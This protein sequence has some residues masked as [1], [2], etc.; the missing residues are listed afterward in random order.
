M[1]NQ[2]GT[3]NITTN[4]RM[5][6]KNEVIRNKYTG[7]PYLV[8]SVVRD[9]VCFVIDLQEHSDLPLTRSLLPKEWSNF[10]ADDEDK[11]TYA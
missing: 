4:P 9:L 2:S 10:I 11:R 7:H 6:Q 3:Q 1:P 5:W 8:L